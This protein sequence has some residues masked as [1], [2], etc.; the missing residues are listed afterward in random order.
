M[1]LFGYHASHEQFPPGEL[2]SLVQA[3]EAAGFDAAMCSDH[4]HPWSDAQGHCG[5]A[6]TWLGSVMATTSLPFGV[7]TSPVGRYHPAVI[8]QAAATLAAMHGERFWLAV[9]SGEALNESITGEHWPL[10]SA[11]NARLREA[12]EVMRALWRGEEVD[13]RGAIVVEQARLYTRPE[14]PLP[15]LAAALSPETARWAGAWADGLITISAPREKMRTLVDAFREG[16]GEGKPV[17]LQVKLSF[18]KK[19]SD[20]LDGAFEQ[21]RTNVFEGTVSEQLRTPAQF[22]AAAA[23]VRP[24]DLR[25]S[26]RISSD[27]ARHLEWLREDLELGVDHVYLHNVNRGQRDFIDAFASDVLPQLQSPGKGGS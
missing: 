6:W 23:H 8:A 27:V 3:A 18:A 19:E 15:V 11:R 7:V 4:F 14:Q 21:W 24:E 13:H 20:A 2:L 1:A 10:K 9:G 16:G 12:V 5:H 25:S 22:E 26:V 17:H